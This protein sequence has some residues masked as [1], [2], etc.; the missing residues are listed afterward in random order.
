MTR[1]VQAIL[2]SLENEERVQLRVSVFEMEK[3][4]TAAIGIAHEQGL[5]C[6][7]YKSPEFCEVVAYFRNGP[8]AWRLAINRDPTREEHD[9]WEAS[10]LIGQAA[11]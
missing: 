7:A 10:E 1:L 2:D 4:V 9:V 3:V 5:S 11:L 6:C 8:D